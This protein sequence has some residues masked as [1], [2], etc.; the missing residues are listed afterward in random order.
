MLF[1]SVDVPDPD[2]PLAPRPSTPTKPVA[3]KPPVTTVEVEIPDEDVP[4]ADVPNTGDGTGLWC[5][6]GLMA[7]AGLAYLFLEEKKRQNNAQ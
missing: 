3:P 7:G 2:V 5:V 6:L 4:L 1:R